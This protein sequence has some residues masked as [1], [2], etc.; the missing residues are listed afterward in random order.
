[1]PPI[2]D[3]SVVLITGATSGIG[4][5]TA[6]LLAA[7]GYRVFGTS[8][9]PPAAAADGYELVPLEVTSDESVAACVQMVADRTG[10]RID[11]L[12]NNVGTG[13]IAA[14]EES[15]PAQAELLFGVNFFGAVR[16]T[17]AVLPGMRGRR[18]GRILNMSSSGGVAAVPFA[19]Y[20][21]ATKHALEAYTAALRH[22]VRPFG[23]TAAVVAPGPVN[24]PAP[25]KA[26]RPDRPLD[27]YA[28]ARLKAAADY[29]RAI[30]HGMDPE[31]VAR[32][33]LRVLRAGRPKP[34]YVVGGQSRIVSLL[35]RVL[36]DRLFEAGVRQAVR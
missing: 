34:R 2:A 17:T 22:E 3:G 12:I 35:R 25:G 15:S 31:R 10:G 18:A 6:R 20:Y 24:T 7:R 21:C 14:A 36:P 11:V 32:A 19:G 29:A 4:R 30:H 16:M 33:V 27:A 1:M 5:A 9:R 28:P 26:L 8:R 13:V 23:I